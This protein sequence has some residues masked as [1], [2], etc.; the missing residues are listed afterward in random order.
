MT[1]AHLVLGG[2]QNASDVLAGA[3]SAGVPLYIAAAVIEKETG[4]ANVY[5]NDRGGVYSTSDPARPNPAAVT[6][7]NYAVFERRVMDGETSNGVGPAQITWPGFITDAKER[8]IRLWV[9][10]ENIA[11]GLS[12]IAGY[13]NG[14]ETDDAIRYAGTRYNGAA[15]YGDDLL[16]VARRWQAAL[17]E[18][19]PV[20]RNHSVAAMATL[21]RELR[22]RGYTITCGPGHYKDGRCRPGRHSHLPTSTHFIGGAVDVSFDPP[23]GAAVS[24]YEK[25]HLDD[26]ARE[27]MGRGYRVIW[28]VANHFDH[29]HADFNLYG[30]GGGHSVVFQGP[31]GG[32]TVNHIKE[33]QRGLKTLKHYT[34]V[35]DGL[36]GAGT[37]SAIKAFQRGAGLTADGAPGGNTMR[38]LKAALAKPTPKPPA[39]KPETPKFSESWIK[40]I[41]TG[42]K[43]LGHYKDAIDGSLGPNT[44]K[45]VKAFQTVAGL[46]VDGLP[47]EDT[48]KALRE[49]LA[50]HSLRER[51]SA[52]R[53]AGAGRSET[54][55][56]IDRWTPP[57][58]LGVL[59]VSDDP[60]DM[61]MAATK[62]SSTVRVLPVPRGGDL[63]DD[64]RARMAQIKPKWVRV[65]GG[66]ISV[67]DETAVEAIEISGRTV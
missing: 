15:A 66:Y 27:L 11:Y 31:N 43:T 46:K 21:E 62:A 7:E 32:F 51:V 12:L 34:G 36:R 2:L 13:L 24:V 56:E 30:N 53:I 23:S 10:A 35:I 41:Q 26:L 18:E 38:A 64:I 54:A 61:A 25:A 16:A 20:A 6:A 28:G 55:A 14:S 29:L 60:T 17:S 8:G 65:V 58:G 67:P 52:Y 48:E 3:L 39:P 37:L 33:V 45:A 44:T 50:A 57:S 42:L 59:I 63:P 22:G 9:P 5:G 4:G 1:V 47:G 19:A 40:A 49:H